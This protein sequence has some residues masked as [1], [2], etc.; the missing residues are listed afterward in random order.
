MIYLIEEISGKIF[1]IVIMPTSL[2]V[3]LIQMTNLYQICMRQPLGKNHFKVF[4][5]LYCEHESPFLSPLIV[6]TF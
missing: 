3:L 5:C 1:A 4:R 2:S 6:T